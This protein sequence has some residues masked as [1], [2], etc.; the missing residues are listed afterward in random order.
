MNYIK[1]ETRDMDSQLTLSH[2]WGGKINHDDND[3]RSIFVVDLFC[4]AGGF[5]CGSEQAGL[6]VALAVDNSKEA[7]AVHCV[8]HRQCKHLCIELGY[9]TEQHLLNEIRKVVGDRLWHL[10][11]SPPCQKLSAMRNLKKGRDRDGG[12]Y[13]V[14]WFFQFVSKAKPNTWSFE[15]VSIPCLSQYLKEQNICSHRFKFC[16]IRLAT[17]SYKTSC[18][19]KKID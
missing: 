11:G 13:L 4:G 18:W 7:L 15:Q 17:N 16:R 5:S 1:N 12:M 14:K 8:N 10:H 6:K 9:K 2:F 3:T 19:I